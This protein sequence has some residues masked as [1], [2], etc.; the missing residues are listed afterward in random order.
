MT[1]SWIVGV[2]D[3]FAGGFDQLSQFR[4]ALGGLP[5]L[6]SSLIG[7]SVSCD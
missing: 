6:A 2:G 1:L 5:S 3:K 7:T 4:C